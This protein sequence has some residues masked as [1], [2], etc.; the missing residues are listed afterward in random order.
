VKK[1]DETSAVDEVLLFINDETNG[2]ENNDDGDD[3][4]DPDATYARKMR[5]ALEKYSARLDEY[6]SNAD[7]PSATEEDKDKE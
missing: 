5:S 2:D 6:A 3:A 1:L 7:A 4:S